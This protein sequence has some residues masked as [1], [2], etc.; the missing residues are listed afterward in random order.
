MDAGQP[1]LSV[2]V[3]VYNFCTYCTCHLS[4]LKEGLLI[5]FITHLNTHL[6]SPLVICQIKCFKVQ[7]ILKHCVLIIF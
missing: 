4:V 7:L 3:T 5:C 2:V 1:L 6:K